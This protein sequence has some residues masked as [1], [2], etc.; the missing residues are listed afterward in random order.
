MGCS[1]IATSA[2]FQAASL[3]LPTALEVGRVTFR[4]ML[5]AELALVVFGSALLVKDHKWRSWFWLAVAILAVQWLG[6]MP[7]LNARTDAVIHGRVAIGPPWHFAY[8]I[9]EV[10]KVFVLLKV[11][12]GQQEG[13]V[14]ADQAG[15]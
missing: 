12:C 11:A 7:L 5:L 15:V 13:E 3:S 4:A 2:K 9:L 10:V 1:F 8:I 6:V 14:A